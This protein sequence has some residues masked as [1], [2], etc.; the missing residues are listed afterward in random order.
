MSFSQ[1]AMVLSKGNEIIKTKAAY[2]DDKS[3]GTSQHWQN[4]TLKQ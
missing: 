2:C 4:D 1:A 3:A